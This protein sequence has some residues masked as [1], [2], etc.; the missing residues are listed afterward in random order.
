MENRFPAFKFVSITQHLY[1]YPETLQ[2]ELFVLKYFE[3]KK[4]N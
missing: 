3:L 2:I 1:V 4:A